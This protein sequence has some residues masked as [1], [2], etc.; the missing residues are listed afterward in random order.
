MR[1]EIY[2][3]AGFR[4]RKTEK[5]KRGVLRPTSGLRMTFRRYWVLKKGKPRTSFVRNELFARRGTRRGVFTESL[6]AA[7]LLFRSE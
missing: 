6:C 1:K 3:R 5:K 4:E 2:A 7:Y